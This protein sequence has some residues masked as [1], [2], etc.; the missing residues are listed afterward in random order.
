MNRKTLIYW[1]APAIFSVLL[2][3][4]GLSQAQSQG[5]DDLDV[6]MRMV[7]DDQELDDSL[8][9]QLELPE[10]ADSPA[11]A[12]GFGDMQ[13]DS[14]EFATDIRENMLDIEDTLADDSL[15]LNDDLG[16]DLGGD[17]ITDEPDLG[18]PGTGDTDL[19]LDTDTNLLNEEPLNV[20]GTQ[21]Q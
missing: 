11:P 15:E 6:T 9:Q 16:I 18:L 10:S 21:L 20:D 8:V 13:M 12:E 14:D 4:P 19:N 5:E 7:A 17:T 2:A 1:F 3:V